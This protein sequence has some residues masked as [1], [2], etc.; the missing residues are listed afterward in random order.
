MGQAG[1]EINLKKL[2]TQ[3]QSQNLRAMSVERD[4]TKVWEGQGDGAVGWGEPF[5]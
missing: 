3:D 4:E 2:K 1:W 5:A